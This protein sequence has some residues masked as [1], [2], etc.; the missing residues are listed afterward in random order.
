MCVYAVY[1]DLKSNICSM[2]ERTKGALH[3]QNVA[4]FFASVS[5]AIAVS[6]RA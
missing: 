1:N 6:H 4:N 3:F 5:F 2:N